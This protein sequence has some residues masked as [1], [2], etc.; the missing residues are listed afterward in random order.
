MTPHL[1][2]PNRHPPSAG[3]ANCW[4]AFGVDCQTCLGM[5]S[6]RQN[7]LCTCRDLDPHLKTV[8]LDP[9]EPNPKRHLYRFSGFCTAHI[10]ASCTSRLVAILPKIAPS[11]GDLDSHNT[12]FLE[13]TRVHTPNGILIGSPFGRAQDRDRQTDRKTDHATPSL[14]VVPHLA[15]AAMRRNW[16]NLFS[17]NISRITAYPVQYILA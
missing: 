13:P 8:I 11:H 17:N 1:A 2:Q 16:Q 4:V 9:S 5:P 14:T 15:S 6:S 3:S 10:R 7:C 12:R